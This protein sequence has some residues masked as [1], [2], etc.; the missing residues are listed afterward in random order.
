M[1]QEQGSGILEPNKSLVFALAALATFPWFF[2]SLD[3]KSR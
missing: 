1:Q 2:H 3:I